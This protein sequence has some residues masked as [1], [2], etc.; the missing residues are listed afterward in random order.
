MLEKEVIKAVS[1]RSVALILGGGRGTRLFPLTLYRAKPAVS[2]GGQYRLIDI[3]ISTCIHSGVHK[4]FILT[5]FLSA[6]LHR[7]ITRTYRFDVFGNHFVDILAAEQTPTNFEYAQGTADAVRQS[8]RYLETMPADYVFI[9]SGDQLFRINLADMLLAHFNANAQIT[10]ATKTVPREEVSRLG[11]LQAAA[12]FR[13]TAFH[14]KPTDEALISSLARELEGTRTFLASMGLYLFNKSVLLHLLHTHADTDFGKG[15][16]PKAIH[17][18]RSH[19]YVFRG[20][21][22]DIGTIRSYFETS[23]RLT[24]EEPPFSF[25]S[26]RAPIYTHPRFLPPPKIMAAHIRQSLI[27]DGTIIQEASI[28]RS[29]IGIR[30]YIKPGCR[31]QET[32]VMGNDVFTSTKPPARAAADEP[33][34]IG[35]NCRLRRVIIDKNVTIGKNCELLGSTDS[36]VTFSGDNKAIFHIIN[37]IIVI[38]RGAVI[39]DNTIIHGDEY[40]S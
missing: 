11:I 39:P 12:D 14:E 37:G 38:P 27:S 13:I 32:I 24:E 17:S 4:I 34:V 36:T 1:N 26:N 19:A 31:I 5:Q 7:H 40:R 21:W 8:I 25:Y 3:P 6:S 18:H 16:L 23:M 2:I 35:E 9:L 33:F 22:Q 20:F 10:L 15:I 28:A 29:I 30:S